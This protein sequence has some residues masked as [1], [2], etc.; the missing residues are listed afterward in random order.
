MVVWNSPRKIGV[1]FM[2][3]VFKIHGTK[4]TPGFFTGVSIQ[5]IEVSIS[6]LEK[7][8]RFQLSETS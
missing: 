7:K 5:R 2:T 6:D 1:R 8:N 3:R 4:K